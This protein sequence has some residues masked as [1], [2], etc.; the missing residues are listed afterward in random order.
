NKS[1]TAERACRRSA[2]VGDLLF[3]LATLLG[4]LFRRLRRALFPSALLG[5]GPLCTSLLGRL[6]RRFLRRG[7]LGPRLFGAALFG[8]CALCSTLAR[9][10]FRGGGLLRSDRLGNGLFSRGFRA[11]GR[12]RRRHL[13]CG[14]RGWGGGGSAARSA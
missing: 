10:G 7:L 14:R 9:G 8:F 11:A 2:V 4:A 6:G 12:R 3:P 5:A 13:R 1:T